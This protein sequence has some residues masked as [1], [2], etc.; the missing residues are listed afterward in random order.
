MPILQRT[1]PSC[2]D[3]ARPRRVKPARPSGQGLDVEPAHV[4]LDDRTAAALVDLLEPKGYGPARRS[5]ALDAIR[6]DPAAGAATVHIDPADRAA[7]R[8]LLGRPAPS[9][10]PAP[11]PAPRVHTREDEAFDLGLRLGLEYERPSS[12]PASF[13]PAERDAFEA[14]Q[15]EAARRLGDHLAELAEQFEAVSL[16][17]EGGALAW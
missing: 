5:K 8:A 9:K 12:P 3:I 17:S 10:A 7:V 16:M 6:R 2:I 4:D 13:R 11:A 15:E 1:R 14:G